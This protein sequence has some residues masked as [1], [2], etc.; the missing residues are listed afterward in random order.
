MKWS[1]RASDRGFLAVATLI[2]LVAALF[3]LYALHDVPPGLA[4]DEVLNADIAG[5][6]LEGRHAL[7]FREG[8]GHEPL[9]HYWSVPFRALLG[10]NVLAIR[11]PA[12]FLGL[13]LVAATLRWARRDFGGLAAL[14]AGTG[15]AISWWPIVFSR[16]GLRP[17]AEPLFLVLAVWVWPRR[18]WL[19]GL[20]LAAAI[21]S[22]T[23]ARYIFVLPLLFAIH[24]LLVHPRAPAR[25]SRPGDALIVFLVAAACFLPLAQT[26][27]ADPTL[28]QRVDQLAGP[29]DAL[30]AGDAGPVWETTVATL[31]V[32][33]FTGDPRW[34]YSLPGRPL[35]DALTSFFFYGG[36]VLAIFRWRRGHYALLLLWLAV[37]LLPSALTPQAPSTVRLVG[38]MP[39][40]YLLPGLAVSWLWQGRRRLH[41]PRYKRVGSAALWL[42]MLLLTGLNAGRTIRDGFGEWPQ[43]A[44]TR[45]SYQTVLLDIARHWEA[46]E[47]AAALV[48][49]DAYYEPIDADSLRRNLGRPLPARWVQTGPDVAGAVVWPSG[50]SVLYLPEYAPPPAALLALAGLDGEPRYRS[51]QTPGFAVYALPPAPPPEVALSVSFDGQIDLLGFSLE[52]N[53]DGTASLLTFWQVLAPLPADLAIFVHLVDGS[54]AIVAQHDA[55]DAAAALLQP[56][57]RFVQLHP[58]PADALHTIQVGL[59]RRGDG[60][61]LEHGGTPPDIVV[62]PDDG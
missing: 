48:V 23:A 41:N 44:A 7:F 39:V 61:R 31:G 12:V 38:A 20:F 57:D 49:A 56:G 1:N 40:V 11:L 27:R 14:V 4:Q 62:L 34:T 55:L 21:Y 60:S 58:V 47:E 33:S 8:Y 42:S 30:R 24:L 10:D 3:R 52:R 32:F 50:E 45:L 35:F 15:L 9:Y 59:Y 18:P 22:Y 29:I 6:I 2:L 36:L 37:T 13:A 16:I 17:I 51:A 28:Q 26:L 5:F 43:A 54:G 53:G 19:A 25:W 46:E